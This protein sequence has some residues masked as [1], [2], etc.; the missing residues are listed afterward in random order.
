MLYNYQSSCQ[1]STYGGAAGASGYQR[2]LRIGANPYFHNGQMPHMYG[3]VRGAGESAFFEPSAKT[4][5]VR[6]QRRRMNL[7]AMFLCLFVPWILFCAMSAVMS[8]SIHYQQPWWCYSVVAAGF[9]VTMVSVASAKDASDNRTTQNPYSYSAREPTWYIFLALSIFLA[10]F[11]GIVVGDLNFHAN[12]EPYYASMTLNMYSNV[13]PS[14]VRGQSLM[15]AGRVLFTNESQLDISR[16]MGFKNSDVYCVAPIAPKGGNRTAIPLANYDFW[17]VGT[18]CCHGNSATF[19]CGEFSNINAHAGLRLLTDDGH[20]FFQLAVQ[21][22]EAAYGIKAPHPLFFTWM[23]DPVANM[24]ARQDAGV[25][26]FLLGM[27]THFGL[28]LVIVI[29]ASIAF[30]KLQPGC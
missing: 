7:M 17:A 5:F 2:G 28:Q 15:D 29:V 9:L 4:A 20:P 1:A 18:N 8:F 3:D 25:K 24:A 30:S 23:Q 26:Y 11:A 14:R 19:H 10:W 12:L 21:Q 22:A 13:D 6:G 16:S 27:F